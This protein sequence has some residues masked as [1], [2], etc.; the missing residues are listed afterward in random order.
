MHA[1][2]NVN[3]V[4]AVYKVLGTNQFPGGSK[5]LFSIMEENR[6]E[7]L[8][9]SPQLV[10]NAFSSTEKNT[11]TIFQ[12]NHLQNKGND[13][14]SE[15][16]ISDQFTGKIDA[17]SIENKDK[18]PAIALDRT[19]IAS[20]K[21]VAEAKSDDTFQQNNIT[22]L[23]VEKQNSDVNIDEDFSQTAATYSRIGASPRPVDLSNIV[24]HLFYST[25]SNEA[26]SVIA[27]ERPDH[28][29][30]PESTLKNLEV[31]K[32]AYNRSEANASKLNYQR[33]DTGKSDSVSDDDIP[34]TN[35]RIA[36]D[37]E[38]ATSIIDNFSVRENA[39]AIE[40]LAKTKFD[41]DHNMAVATNNFDEIVA[42]PIALQFGDQIHTTG[43]GRNDNLT[44]VYRYLPAPRQSGKK[45][46]S[47]TE[48][49]V[50]DPKQDADEKKASEKQS[51]GVHS[52]EKVLGK[53]VA[54]VDSNTI[55]NLND[56]GDSV[57]SSY[58]LPNSAE[59]KDK[60]ESSRNNAYNKETNDDNRI[61]P[62]ATDTGE[63]VL[64][65]PIVND[66]I[67]KYSFKKEFESPDLLTDN[68]DDEPKHVDE[69]VRKGDIPHPTV[70]VNF[71]KLKDQSL[72]MLSNNKIFVSNFKGKKKP[73]SLSIL[74]EVHSF[75]L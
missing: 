30:T 50:F 56:E 11:Q 24:N 9:N 2:K 68:I 36:D 17:N 16:V 3:F 20:D 70:H 62:S 10:E 26:K 52:L 73:F 67:D 49:Q 57:T 28:K 32:P 60:N 58:I 37:Y 42:Y 47:S 14:E 4:F 35:D 48:E 59:E 43:G 15:N 45:Q 53:P 5:P 71:E 7:N 25:T 44:S 74:C 72:E 33:T 61:A 64:E 19:E 21:I 18:E 38:K 75:L 34:V 63:T 66:K 27:S 69:V 55:L 54:N 51:N 40:L 12:E 22:Q 23:K 13:F 31:T 8:Q 41:E 1:F 46:D 6:Q 65:N 29:Q 39:E